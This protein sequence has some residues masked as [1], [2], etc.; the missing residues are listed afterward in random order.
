MIQICL[1]TDALGKHSQSADVSK[2]E[3]E[4]LAAAFKPLPR[5]VADLGGVVHSQPHTRTPMQHYAQE[6]GQP[7]EYLT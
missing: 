1:L 4:V 6:P 5:I 3:Q 2:L 7:G